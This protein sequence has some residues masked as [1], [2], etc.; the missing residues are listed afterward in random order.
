MPISGDVNMDQNDSDYTIPLDS[1]VGCNG[2]TPD[3]ARD[4]SGP[5]KIPYEGA[6]SAPVGYDG[7]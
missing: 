1:C 7:P 5:A 6:G 3:Q 2:P 4:I